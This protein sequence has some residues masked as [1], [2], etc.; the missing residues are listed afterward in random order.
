MAGRFQLGDFELD[1]SAFTLRRHGTPVR[2]EKIPM[3]V[4]VLLVERAGT[5]IARD[6]IHAAL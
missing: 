4:L 3:E 5:L 2:L 1:V 6:S